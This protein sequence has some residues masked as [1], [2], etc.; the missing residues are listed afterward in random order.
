M[1]TGRWVPLIEERLAR[2][3]SGTAPTMTAADTPITVYSSQGV[4]EAGELAVCAVPRS[5]RA[6]MAATAAPRAANQSTTHT[7]T[8]MRSV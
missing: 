6:T 7:A 5:T 8:R 4:S 3:S 2:I 1:A